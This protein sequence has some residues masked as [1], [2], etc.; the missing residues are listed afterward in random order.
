LIGTPHRWSGG[1]LDLHQ[2]PQDFLKP[3]EIAA[4]DEVARASPIFVTA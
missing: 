1:C 3:I 2:R 4:R